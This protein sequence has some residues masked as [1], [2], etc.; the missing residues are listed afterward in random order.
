MGPRRYVLTHTPQRSRV[1]Y[2]SAD[3]SLYLFPSTFEVMLLPWTITE[4]CCSAILTVFS[5]DSCGTLDRKAERAV[6]AA[7]RGLEEES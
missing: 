2:D 6:P 5:E 7:Q 1:G 3:V 4:V